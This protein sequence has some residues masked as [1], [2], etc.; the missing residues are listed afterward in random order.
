MAEASSH[1][2]PPPPDVAN[3]RDD[4]RCPLCDYNLR[5]LAEPRC[6]ECG[7]RFEWVDL[8]D[9]ARRRH[10][11]LFEHHPERNVWSFVRTLLAGLRPRRFWTSI[12][13]AQPS[14]LRRLVAYWLACCLLLAAAY[15]AHAGLWVRHTRAT[16][17]ARL[18][19][20]F[21]TQYAPG[22]EHRALVEKEH[23]SFD[24]FVARVIRDSRQSWADG[25]R[26]ATRLAALIVLWPWLVFLALLV[27]R[28]SMCR[29]RIR[30]VHVLRC[31]VYSYDAVAWL[32]VIVAAAAAV[33]ASAWLGLLPRHWQTP[34]ALLPVAP[35][36]RD[37]V[38]RYN[39]DV[40]T[41]TLFWAACL[42]PLVTAYRLASAFRH[43]LRFNR[44]AATVFAA[45]VVAGLLLAVALVRWWLP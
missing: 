14:R 6:P 10:P 21:K 8:T 32:A 1:A 3:A 11:Y 27:F 9:P 43:Y 17:R 16:D 38:F 39:P 12:H 28:I 34:G 7:F 23:G 37:V 19:L 15:A 41:D 36:P 22:S 24:A 45:H 25:G 31:V 42:V 35:I 33:K 40:V 26:W 4:V 18:A 13:P 30:P 2:A 20:W 5:G 44:P 29:A